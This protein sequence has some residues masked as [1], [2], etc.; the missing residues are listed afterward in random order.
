[1]VE[2]KIELPKRPDPSRFEINMFDNNHCNQ[3]GK[4]LD[5]HAFFC[6]DECVRESIKLNRLMRDT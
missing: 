2:E 6:S 4:Q 1:M 3:C 5:N